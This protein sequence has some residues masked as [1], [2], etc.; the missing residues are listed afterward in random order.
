MAL[1]STKAKTLESLRGQLKNAQVLPQVCFTVAEWNSA[2]NS[3]DVLEERPLWFDK[4]IIVRSSGQAEDTQ[5]KSLAGHFTTVANVIGEADLLVA[6]KS[7]IDSFC[8][9][10]PDDQ[11]F[12]QPMLEDVLV[13]GV[14]FTRDPNNGGYYNVINYDELSGSTNTVTDGQSNDLITF[15][16]AKGSS[17]PTS[18]WLKNLINLLLEL[19]RYFDLDSI[20]VEFAVDK[21]GTLFLFQVRPLIIINFENLSIS[22]HKQALLGIEKSFLSLTAK[23]PY[24]LG[25]NSIFGVMPDWN[26][27]EVIGIRPR[28][29][30]L[31]LYKE[32]VTDSVWAYQRDNYGYRN[33]RSFPLLVIFAGLPY[34]DVRVSFNS[35]IPSD[36][37]D[38]IAERLVNHYIKHLQDNPNHHDKVEF[39]IIYSCYTLDLPQRLSALEKFGFNPKEQIQISES[40]RKL[41][42][43]II[44]CEDGLW[45][46]DI[47]KLDKLKHRQEKINKSKLNITEKI[48]WLLEDCK[49]YGTL[50]FA[51]LARAGFIA[52]QLLKS[53]VRVGVLTEKE[54]ECFMGSLDTVS[55]SM[56]EDFLQLSRAL[57]LEKYGHLRPGTYDILSLR[58]DEAPERYFAWDSHCDD[59]PKIR[60]KDFSLSLN[61]TNRLEV[62]L[63]EHGFE[64]DA[65]S[66]FNFIKGAIEG[67]EYAKFVFTKSLSDA[68][69][70]IEKLGAEYGIDKNDLSY[71]N[72]NAI[73]K[74]YSS[75]QDAKDSLLASI[76]EGKKDYAK[77]R[78]LRLPPLISHVEEISS[79]ELPKN[80]PNFITLQSVKGKVVTD[81]ASREDLN[82][83]ILI[84]QSAD[85]GYDWIFSHGIG[86]FITMYGGAN[87]HM[88]IRAGELGIPAVIG[89]GEKLYKYWSSAKFIEI[90]CSNK[91][92]RILR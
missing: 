60:G 49:R 17:L 69:V 70:L 29:L 26:P 73:R 74:L 75:S 56:S 13:S 12:I 36:L 32:L 84:I 23:H 65:L 92:V 2:G 68:L 7:V 76:E 78:S 52:V 9:N 77:T 57:F 38:E 5:T 22:E 81:E 45:R 48:Y 62:L 3:L 80:E 67:R 37:S 88:A 54:Y 91:Y 47:K 24:L 46:K 4:P 71:V 25:K 89:A 64:H 82:G 53:L 43:R 10:N 79:F 19:E 87:S 44:H 90:D 58:Y 42:N 14:A 16:H 59:I 61:A 11:V 27:A 31:S 41:T 33:L 50:P 66:L 6:I 20:D 18:G 8:G 1:F 85:P 21:K 51:G 55:S 28:P 34:I 40:L 86:G 72:L 83:N 63:A 30:A 39:E 35:F 15:Y